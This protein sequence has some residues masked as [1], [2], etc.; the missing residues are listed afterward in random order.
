MRNVQRDF[1]AIVGEVPY[2]PEE[3][4]V[5][6]A[7][8]EDPVMLSHLIAGRD[9]AATEEK[10]SLLEELDVSKRLRRLSRDPGTGAGGG[11]ARHQDPV[12]GPV[13]A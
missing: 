8:V 9:A 1:G 6:V 4:S 12:P 2:L 7:N 13:R 11:R 3:L 10:Q 5:M